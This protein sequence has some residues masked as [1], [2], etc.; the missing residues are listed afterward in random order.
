M[1]QKMREILEET[2]TFYGE[3]N[4]RR[5]TSGIGYCLYKTP[6]DRC[7]A[8]GRKFTEADHLATEKHRGAKL[9]EI[10]DDITSP[11]IKEL[12]FR[13][14]N[15]LQKLHDRSAHWRPGGLTDEGELLANR[16]RQN[17]DRGVYK[18]APPEESAAAED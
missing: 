7:C 17:I 18:V 16:I 9:E 10:W 14:W 5:A 4:S 2:I 13:F 8:V 11:A 12:P 1:K 3:D 15:A 6:D